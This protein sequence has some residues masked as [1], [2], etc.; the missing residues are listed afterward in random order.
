[1]SLQSLGRCVLFAAAALLPAGCV[2]EIDPPPGG[3]N[4]GPGPTVTIRIVNESD[5]GLDPQI[6]FSATAGTRDELFNPANKFTNFGVL[7]SGLLDRFSSDSF[8]V[9]CSQAR[10]I[11]TLGGSFGGN[12]NNPEGTGT[13]RLVAQ[14]SFFLCGETITF[15]YRRSGAGFTTSVALN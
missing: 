9:E 14:D 10:L 1:M 7:G 13:E 8:T 15:I 11:G 12:I 5:T 2:I 6:F 3:G 4:G